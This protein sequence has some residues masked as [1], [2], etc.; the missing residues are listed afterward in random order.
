MLGGLPYVFGQI[1]ILFIFV[2]RIRYSFNRSPT[3]EELKSLKTIYILIGIDILLLFITIGVTSTDGGSSTAGVAVGLLLWITFLVLYLVN[4]YLLIRLFWKKILILLQQKLGDVESGGGSASENDAGKSNSDSI[5]ENHSNPNSNS[6]KTSNNDN[7]DSQILLRYLVSILVAFCT[8]IIL[9]VFIV[10]Y[11]SISDVTDDATYLIDPSEVATGFDS[12]MNGFCILLLFPSKIG[13][14]LYV[15]LFM[16]L[17]NR[18]KNKLIDKFVK[19]GAN[20]QESIQR[21]KSKED[22]K[23][24]LFE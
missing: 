17:Q 11:L 14:W 12:M 4:Y 19:G 8:T 9:S 24:L 22:Y 16:W 15:H 7:K 23:T 18:L 3:D 21:Q 10:I 20:G 13:D 2:L 1:T 6:N 5:S